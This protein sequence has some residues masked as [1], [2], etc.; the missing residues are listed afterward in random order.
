MLSSSRRFTL[1]LMQFLP[2][3]QGHHVLCQD[4]QYSGSSLSTGREGLGSPLLGQLAHELWT[5]ALSEVSLSE[6]HLPA[7]SSEH[8]GRLVVQGG[9]LSQESGGSIRRLLRR[10]GA[11]SGRQGADLFASRETTHCPMFFSLGRGQ[12]T[13]GDGCSSSPVGLKAC[14]TPFPLSPF[15]T[16]CCGGSRFRESGG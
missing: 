6:S 8:S 9:P 4:R 5:W 2:R 13:T 3:L 14:C 12:P 10:S 11:T 1:R 16:R 7:R 15:S